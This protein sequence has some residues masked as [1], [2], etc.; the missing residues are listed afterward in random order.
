MCCGGKLRRR[1]P[2]GQI[3]PAQSLAK[4][5]GHDTV[6]PDDRRKIL[7]TLT[8]KGESLVQRLAP[9]HREELSR[10]SPEI[11]RTLQQIAGV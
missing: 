1:R 11:I 9:L 3:L 7:L 6:A 5:G 4:A 2:A 8:D 10:L